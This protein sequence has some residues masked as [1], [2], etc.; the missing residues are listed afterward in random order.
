MIRRSIRRALRRV[1]LWAIQPHLDGLRRDI[2]GMTESCRLRAAEAAKEE[3]GRL[4][5]QLK[6]LQA[7]DVGYAE[8][9]HIVL[10]DTV[11]GRDFVK[12]IPIRRDCGP[13]EWKDTVKRL[14]RDFAARPE[15]VDAPP[16][17][18]RWLEYELRH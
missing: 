15:Y 5:A 7:L 17:A 10:I 8:A 9:G 18:R 14:E 16:A 6:S 4:R 11:G 12:I 2:S 3:A 13:K 1:I